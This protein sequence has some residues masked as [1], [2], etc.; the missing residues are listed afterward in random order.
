MKR[1]NTDL[2][3]KISHVNLEKPEPATAQEEE[4]KILQEIECLGKMG[5][6]YEKEIE[7]LNAKLKT[8][9]GPDRVVELEKKIYDLKQKQDD[10]FKKKKVMEKKIKDTEK[11][12]EKDSGNKASG[13]EQVEVHGKECEIF[14]SKDS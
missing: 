8:R 1:L 13:N 14:R 3:N 11:I 4:G 7:A 6:V 5:A 12:F 2:D 10:M 9:A